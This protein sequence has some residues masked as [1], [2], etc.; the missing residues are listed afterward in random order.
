MES[1]FVERMLEKLEEFLRALNIECSAASVSDGNKYLWTYA[2][3]N[4]T[5]Y[6]CIDIIWRYIRDAAWQICIQV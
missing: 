2:N 5:S 3:N 1:D 6:A 4:K